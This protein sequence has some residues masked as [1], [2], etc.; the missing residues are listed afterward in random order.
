[1]VGGELQRGGGTHSDVVTKGPSL[2]VFLFTILPPA[3]SDSLI[4][5][6]NF[7]PF[8]RNQTPRKPQSVLYLA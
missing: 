2:N 1:M 6:L 3:P 4:S 8:L 5:C 7:T